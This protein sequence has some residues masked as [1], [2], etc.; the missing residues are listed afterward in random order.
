VGE[1]SYC[2][3][4]AL[5]RT[6]ALTPAGGYRDDLIAGEEPELCVRLRELG[7]KIWRLDREMTLHDAAITRVSQ[8]WRRSERTGFAF[9]EGSRLHGTGPTRHWVRETRSAQIWAGGIPLLIVVG[10][11]LFGPVAAFA[12]MS[13]PLQVARLTFRGTGSLKQRLP[14]A[15]FLVLGKFAELC[16]QLRFHS[17][18]LVGTGAGLI[19]YK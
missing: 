3:G 16:G 9:A 7:W 18:R 17:R 12:L 5:I 13:Y 1:A 2:G 19:E 10:V 14:R 4:D 8:W 11:I 6:A 15:L